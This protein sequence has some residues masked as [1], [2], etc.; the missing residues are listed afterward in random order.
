MPIT[1]ERAAFIRQRCESTDAPT[2]LFERADVVAL[3]AAAEERDRLANRVAHFEKL[4]RPVSDV[5]MPM[6]SDDPNYF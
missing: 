2:M 3:L 5:D 6:R 1:P 4:L